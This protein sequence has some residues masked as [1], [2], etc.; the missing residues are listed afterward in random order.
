MDSLRSALQPITHALPAPI[1]ELGT[2][3]IGDV[4]YKTLVL[5]IN[6]ESTECLKLAISKGLGLGIIAAS[7]IVKIPQILKLLSSKS[8]SGISFLS[9]FLETSAYLISLAY[10]YRQGFPFSTY[11]ETALIAV[12]NVVIAVLVLNYSGKSAGAAVF[13]AGLAA[14]GA[15]LFAPNIL[16][17]QTLSYFQ[18]GAGV[19]GVASKLPQIVAVWQEGGTGQLSAF[20]V[21]NYLLGSLSRIFTTLQEV[22]DKLILYGFIAGFALNAILAAQMVYYWNAPAKKSEKAKGKMP[23]GAG[24]GAGSSTATPKAKSPT[25]RRR[26]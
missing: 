20:A 13:V 9:Y 4:C 17:M 11:G 10:N 15:A 18:A 1:H 22:D 25:T 8:S 19:L 16:D 3:I 21:F 7:S 14:S 6:L 23:I 12:Q 5:D 2:S 26:G 24:S